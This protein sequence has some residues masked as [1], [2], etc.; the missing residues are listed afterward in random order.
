MQ[1]HLDYVT[2]CLGID[3]IR[4]EAATTAT[5]ADLEEQVQDYVARLATR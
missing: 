2:S 5:L 3:P 1:N 4:A